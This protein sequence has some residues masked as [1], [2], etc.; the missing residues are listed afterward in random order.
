MTISI[1]VIPS[2]IHQGNDAHVSNVTF[3]P[4]CE[5]RRAER[6]RERALPTSSLL[7]GRIDYKPTALSEAGTRA[8]GVGGVGGGAGGCLVSACKWKSNVLFEE[9]KTRKKKNQQHNDGDGERNLIVL[10]DFLALPSPSTGDAQTA[11]SLEFRVAVVFQGGGQETR[12]STFIITPSSRLLRS[13]ATTTPFLFDNY[14]PLLANDSDKNK[15]P[16]HVSPPTQSHS[17]SH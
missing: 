1:I 16:A 14:S 13:L 11:R 2:V 12:T 15:S 17:R 9:Q 7:C 10:S 4:F 3:I 6:E 5:E 8:G